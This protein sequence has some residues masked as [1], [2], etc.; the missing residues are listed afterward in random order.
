MFQ[1]VRVALS[2]ATGCNVR[3]FHGKNG[4]AK[5]TSLTTDFQTTDEDRIGRITNRLQ[6]RLKL[7]DSSRHEVLGLVTGKGAS[8]HDIGNGNFR[9]K[10]LPNEG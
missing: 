9:S 10:L 4:E 3:W 1:T 5:R 2:E 8:R 7:S 6:T